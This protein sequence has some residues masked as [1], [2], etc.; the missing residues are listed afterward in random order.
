MVANIHAAW[1]KLHRSLT[2]E[3]PNGGA[4]RRFTVRGPK[5]DQCKRPRQCRQRGACCRRCAWAPMMGGLGMKTPFATA[6]TRMGLRLVIP[7]EL[8]TSLGLS[9]A[10]PGSWSSARLWIAA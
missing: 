1:S 9:K 8:P 2:A 3:S 6:T 7:A 4:P 5:P 10:M